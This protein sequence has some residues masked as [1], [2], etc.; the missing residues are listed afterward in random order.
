MKK[1][2]IFL[3]VMLLM[4]GAGLLLIVKL[5]LPAADPVVV[6]P[7]FSAVF[8]D[9]GQ[10]D[11][12]LLGYG[13]HWLLIDGGGN[14]SSSKI[15]SVLKQR[16]I[17]HLELVI[18]SH[19]HEDHI[20]GLSAA[21]QIAQV[22]TV[23]CPTDNAQGKSFENLKRFAQ[24]KSS[25]ITVPK[26]GDIYT[27]GKIRVEILGLNTGPT[28]N[29]RSMVTKV[30]FGNSV[31]LFP[32]D[33]EA[34]YVPPDWDL[35]AT[36]LKVSHHGSR[37]GTSRDLLERVSPRYAVLSLGAENPYNMPHEATLSLLK[38][39]CSV[40]FRTDLQGDITFHSDGN[41]LQAST[42]KNAGSREI[43]TPG[44]GSSGSLEIKETSSDAYPYVINT[45]SRVFHNPD[46]TSTTQMKES[47]KRFSTET[48][49]EL[50]AAGYKPCG[51][52]KP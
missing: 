19:S 37:N 35:S 24:E 25:G 51:N 4:I 5:Y 29:A 43:F 52:C 50:I 32:G 7:G 15:Y 38:D 23:L 11:A 18:A 33:M 13:D 21:F 48:R 12:A 27:L 9:V 30:S 45:G 16:G 40:V 2:T 47:N 28:E 41:T 46:C 31:F 26:A 10:G 34:E 14:G 6:D 8:L 44:D 36:V 42:R 49:E 39:T 22:D 17:T 20:G 3:L 1:R